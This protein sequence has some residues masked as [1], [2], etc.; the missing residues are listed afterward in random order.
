MPG[1]DGLKQPIAGEGEE[2][3][4]G[5]GEGLNEKIERV[6]GVKIEKAWT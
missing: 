6:E 4:R 1:W 2:E 5:G 3:T